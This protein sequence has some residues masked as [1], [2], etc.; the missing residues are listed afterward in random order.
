MLP[1]KVVGEVFSVV[2]MAGTSEFRLMILAW[3]PKR[4]E[5]PHCADSVRNDG[6]LHWAQARKRSLG[7]AGIPC[8]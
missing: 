1:S 2:G 6:I 5:I 4:R 3:E 8:H 7:T